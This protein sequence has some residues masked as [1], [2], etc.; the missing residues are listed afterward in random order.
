MNP[1]NLMT[2]LKRHRA[3]ANK[4]T[5]LCIRFIVEKKIVIKPNPELDTSTKRSKKTE[6]KIKIKSL[7]RL[8]KGLAV[9]T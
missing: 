7:N 1:I 4:L 9:L 2:K 3:I 6:D 5:F 8:G